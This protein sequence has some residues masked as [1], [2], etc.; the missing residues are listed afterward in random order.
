MNKNYSKRI[1]E[2][3]LAAR[4]ESARLESQTVN[5]EHLLLAV[6]KSDNV[7][8]ET[9]FSSFDVDIKELIL[10]LED[11]AI[12]TGGGRVLGSIPLN[13]GVEKILRNTYKETQLL[14]SDVI[15]DEH[16]I[17]SI[18]NTNEGIAAKVL[19]DYG[20]NYSSF[21]FKIQKDS[22]QKDETSS[23]KP[24]KS[25]TPALDHFS[26]DLTE[27]A[28]NDKLDPVI[29]R[30]QEIERMTQILSRRKKNNPVLIG[31]PGVGK[32]AIVEGLALRIINKKVPRILY[33]K[34]LVALDLAAIVAGT[35]YRGQFE[36]RMKKI[37]TELQEI[38][39]TILF[40][41]E[42]HTIVG[43][44]GAGTSLD[45]SNMFKPALARGN[46]QCI[47]A[48]TLDEYRKNIEKDGALDRRF[49]EVIVK[50]PSFQETFDILKGLKIR[51][52][53][54]HCV[55]Y[56]DEALYA[57]VELSSKYITNNFLPDKAI[58]VM[59]EAGSRVHIREIKVP[60]EVTKIEKGL[61]KIILLKENVV[62]EQ[63]FEQAAQLRDQERQLREKLDKEKSK[64]SNDHVKNPVGVTSED[65]ADVVTMITGIPVNKVLETEN[66]KL[67][68]MEENLCKEII[69]QNK[70]IRI[71]SKAIRRSR[72]GLKDPL[73]PIG[74]FMF[75]GPTGVGKTEL[76]K[77][78]SKFLF[79]KSDALIKVDMSEYM[80]KFA[81]SKMVGAPPGYIGYENAGE[82]TER[83]R[84][85]P[86]SVVLFDEIEKAHP[87]V[88][89]ILLQIFDEGNI[90][91]NVGR[92]IDFKNTIIILTSNIGTKKISKTS[93]G[94]ESENI[95]TQSNKQKSM[96]IKEAKK[97]FKPEFINRL[98]ELIVFNSLEKEDI[99]QIIDLQ[100]SDVQKNVES[101]NINLV[102]TKEAKSFL[103]DKGYDKQYGARA[104]RR[105][106]RNL[107]E[108]KLAEAFLNN[109]V[110][111]NQ[112]ILIDCKGNKLEFTNIADK[113]LPSPINYKDTV[114]IES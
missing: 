77:I 20:I 46:I 101:R 110:N 54:H 113:A 59:D 82:L 32:T 8:V 88:F 114:E 69:G 3:I 56:S 30:G 38:E 18:L 106:I 19:H 13:K 95:I 102:F 21:K 99:L 76:A 73:R 75:L 6:L 89:N 65:M 93:L 64:W 28:R 34:R 1:Q 23:Q 35:K 11:L 67:V 52:E 39:D 40:I 37:M 44:G 108:D 26:Q 103:L 87:D 36:E 9:L 90:T 57:A 4:E 98:D 91:D 78:L 112:P 7:L 100:L 81:V 86:Y 5:S 84:K 58:D 16:I 29:G 49:Q 10:N 96:I 60:H 74:T 79:N 111:D 25:K 43:A 104:I 94:F 68:K 17:L 70:A 27:L 66:E 61:E 48:T 47:G 71:L 50:Q 14:D 83:V 41:D 24:S 63:N 92:K 107:V 12:A 53:N 55:K 42:I 45:A 2:L 85:N 15:K 22:F 97:L 51:Y 105:A 62:K 31:E 109:I 80:E 72:A 33:D